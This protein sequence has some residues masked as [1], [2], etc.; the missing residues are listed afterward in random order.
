[1]RS[2]FAYSTANAQRAEAKAAK[3]QAT[4]ISRFHPGTAA[5]HAV[6]PRVVARPGTKTFIDSDDLTDLTRLFSYVGQATCNHG[7]PGLWEVWSVTD[8]GGDGQAGLG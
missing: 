2:A 5:H 1:M 7:G 6:V 4:E 3:R 8:A